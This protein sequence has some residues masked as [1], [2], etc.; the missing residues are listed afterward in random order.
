MQKFICW[1]PHEVNSASKNQVSCGELMYWVVASLS[2]VE[3]NDIWKSSGSFFP[4]VWLLKKFATRKG[5]TK[6][7]LSVQYNKIKRAK[8]HLLKV[9]I[10][11]FILFLKN[12][13]NKPSYF[14]IT[15][16]LLLNS[17]YEGLSLKNN[18]TNRT[19][20]KRFFI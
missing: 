16:G 6:C 3:I 7:T 19:S 18:C 20:F 14:K 12:Q 11:S 2:L 10:L 17:L 9:P 13:T 8:S 4:A 1:I 5:N 15:M